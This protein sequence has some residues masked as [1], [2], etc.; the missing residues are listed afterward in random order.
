MLNCDEAY[1]SRLVELEVLAAMPIE[2]ER[3]ND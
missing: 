2:D 3:F 1:L